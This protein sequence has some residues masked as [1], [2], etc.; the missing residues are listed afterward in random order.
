MGLWLEQV[1]VGQGYQ[2][3]FSERERLAALAQDIAPCV[4]G[5]PRLSV[6]YDGPTRMGRIALVVHASELRCHGAIAPDG[7]VDLRPLTKLTAPLATWRNRTAAVTDMRLYAFRTALHITDAWGH[8]TLWLDGQDPIDGTAYARC[9]G[10]DGFDRCPH[11]R[12]AARDGVLAY[13]LDDARLRNRFKDL[14]GP[15]P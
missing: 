14:L 8:A 15:V 2:V 7:S 6:T 12:E 5:S 3:A 13:P 1:G 4:S 9:V 10:L 11:T